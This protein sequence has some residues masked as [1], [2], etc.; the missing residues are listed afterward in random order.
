[1]SRVFYAVILTAALACAASAQTRGGTA[2]TPAQPKPAAARPSQTPAA[3]PTPTPAARPAA[4]PAA[5]PAATPA[6]RPAATPAA[7]APQQTSAADACGCE[8]GPLPEVLGMVN[9]VK[10]TRADIGAQAQQRV[11]QL[12]QE[13]VEARKRE[14]DLQ[15]N[16]ILLEAEAK[17][18]GVST[19][20]LLEAEVVA[21]VPEPTAAEA[22][23]YF[24]QNKARVEQ[25]AGRAVTFAELKDNVIAFLREQR[26][27]ERSRQFAESLRAAWPVK[28][29]VESAPPPATPADRARVL[30]TVNG[31]NI[32]SADIEDALL[33]LVAGVQEQVYLLRKGD[34]DMKINDILLGGEAQKRGVTA[35]AVL[36]AEVTSKTPV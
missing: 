21:K 17:K 14:L 19:V 30:A 18:R 13:V 5:K 4:T 9:G 6:A 36:T 23:A 28:K 35:Q 34:V 29:S 26:Q 10:I 22:Q 32:T 15:I 11:A 33:P 1:M 8:A 27:E 20:K 16:S 3:R 24:E 12:Q 31:R 7:A 25:Q 2:A